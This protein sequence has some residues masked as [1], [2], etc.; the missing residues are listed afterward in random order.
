MNQFIEDQEHDHI[1]I[2]L[3][4]KEIDKEKNLELLEKFLQNESIHSSSESDQYSSLD[5]LNKNKITVLLNKANENIKNK[6]N[7][8]LNKIRKNRNITFQG[9]RGSQSF[10]LKLLSNQINCVICGNLIQKD[11][12]YKRVDKEVFCMDCFIDVYQGI[13]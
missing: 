12:Q 5:K 1:G 10:Q 9:D 7:D 2:N 6:E 4:N 3:N 11:D 8:Y 13:N